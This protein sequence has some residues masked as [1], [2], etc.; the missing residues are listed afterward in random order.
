[1]SEMMKLK[2]IFFPGWAMPPDKS[3]ARKLL[4]DELSPLELVDYGFFAG[5]GNFDFKNTESEIDKRAAEGF[6][7]A[8]GYSLGSHFALRIAMASKKI[9]ALIIISGFAKFAESSENADGQ[10]TSKIKAMGRSLLI[11]PSKTLRDF[12]S[13]IFPPAKIAFDC[14]SLIPS[15][16]KMAQ[17]L[18]F[19]SECDLSAQIGRINIPAIVIAASDDVIVST[20]LSEKLATLIP[21]CKF[22]KI[23]NAGHGI[24]FTHTNEIKLFIQ[25]FIRDGNILRQ[26]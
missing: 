14:D 1:M 20:A 9:K 21:G 12:Y 15:P 11:Q 17:G 7:V 22:I 26:G 3:M 25:E 4:P 10:K 18:N 24:P 13:I 8:V 2:T 23:E 16:G 19:L 6:E 5:S